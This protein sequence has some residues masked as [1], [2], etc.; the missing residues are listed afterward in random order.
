MFWEWALT[1]INVAFALENYIGGSHLRNCCPHYRL[2]FRST[3]DSYIIERLPLNVA[4][5]CC[6]HKTCSRNF[7]YPLFFWR[8]QKVFSYNSPFW[9]NFWRLYFK[10]LKVFLTFIWEIAQSSTVNKYAAHLENE[11]NISHRWAA[12]LTWI[13]TL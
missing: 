1:H 2:C 12:S 7:K 9:E 13:D 5:K 4:S 11:N 6:H 8:C 3:Y 10:F